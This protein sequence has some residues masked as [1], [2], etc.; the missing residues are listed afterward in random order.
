MRAM[1][2][3]NVQPFFGFR[4]DLVQS[5]K[6]VHVQ[7]RLAV[8]SIESFDKTVLHGLAELDK[9]KFDAGCFCPIG[10]PQAPLTQ[11]HCRI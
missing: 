11:I 10:D 2:I 1:L 8:T 6:V 9:L 7:N 3:I 4:S 5:F